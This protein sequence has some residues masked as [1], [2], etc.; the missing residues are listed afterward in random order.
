[1]PGRSPEKRDAGLN[2]RS[3]GICRLVTALRRQR[4]PGEFDP[5]I[6]YRCSVS[7]YRSVAYWLG[8]PFGTVM[9][10]VRFL[11]L[12]L[13]QMPRRDYIH[14]KGETQVRLLVPGPDPG[15]G[16]GSPR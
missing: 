12:R 2:G 10:Q 11:S 3:C 4:S 5:L 9:K 8:T 7:I 16:N 1:M 6:P 14:Y 13:R 15:W